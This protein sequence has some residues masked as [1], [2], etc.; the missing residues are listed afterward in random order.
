MQCNSKDVCIDS[1]TLSELMAGPIDFT[2]H[3]SRVY[4][5]LHHHCSN[6]KESV[7]MKMVLSNFYQEPDERC[8]V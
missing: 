7:E 5:V 8:S 6:F 1:S 2:L 4:F 3:P